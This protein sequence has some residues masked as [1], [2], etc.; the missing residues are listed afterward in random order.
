MGL[1]ETPACRILKGNFEAA[2]G[3]FALL[4]GA[5]FK[6]LAG[7]RWRL[8]SSGRPRPRRLG[9]T[10]FKVY[11]PVAAAAAAVVVYVEVHW[12]FRSRWSPIRGNAVCRFGSI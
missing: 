2:S 7:R 8:L 5:A 11:V 4:Q 6:L 10:G 1:A 12:Q 3:R 9:P